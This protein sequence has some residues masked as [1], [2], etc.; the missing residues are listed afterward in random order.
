MKKNALLA[1]GSGIVGGATVALAVA[2]FG[3]SSSSGTTTIEGT[4]DPGSTLSTIADGGPMSAREIYKRDAPGV[5]FIR[6]NVVR[7]ATDPW[8]FDESQSGVSTGS[9]FV[10]DDSGL[11]LT[12]AHVVSGASSIE[13]KFD[14]KLTAPARVLGRDESTDI[15]LLKVDPKGLDLHPL[16]LGDSEALQ[17]GDPTLAIGNPFA[18]ERTLTTGV[19][20]ALKR[21]IKAPNGF[22]IDGVI[23]TDAAINPGNSGGPL[24]NSGG[25]VVGINSQIET[26]GGSEGNVGIGFAVPIA[27]AKKI[28]PQLQAGKRV[29]RGWLGISTTTIDRSLSPL[30]LPSDFGALVQETLP[31]GP[32][33]KAGIRAGNRE[34]TISG[35]RIT[36]GGD[37]IVAV[38]GREVK[39][40]DDLQREIA[41]AKPGETIELTI[42][43]GSE[44]RKVEVKLGKRPESNR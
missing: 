39:T 40:S 6:A 44:T 19:V 24:I 35:S 32:A 13:V 28:L 8:G 4:R 43:R 27:T 41:G 29:E 25:E 21:T 36:V 11:I 30:R 42:K 20:S 18:L 23:Q 5:V 15:A 12:N 3:L 26:G 17:V 22:E 37:V 31:G 38:D 33:A 7:A 14:D 9:G 10:I 2:V 1:I 16:R 34:V